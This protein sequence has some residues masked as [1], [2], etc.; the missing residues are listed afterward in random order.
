M[1]EKER[2]NKIASVSKYAFGV[3]AKTI[4]YSAKLFLGFMVKEGRVLELGPAE[5]V[6]TELLY[7]YFEDYTVV[8]GADMFVEQITK[9]YPK[10][11]GVVSLFEDYKPDRKFDNII[12]GHVLEH[13]ENP[14]EILRRCKSWLRDGGVVLAAVP[15]CDSIHRQAAVKMGLLDSV[16]Q[17]NAAD[18]YHGH[19]RVYNRKEFIDDFESADFKIIKEGGYWLKPLSNA[20]VEENWTDEMVTAFMELGEKYPEIAA[21]IYVVAGK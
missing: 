13:V 6:M 2:I 1:D 20:Q 12:L 16:K 10:I 17:L 15:N 4:I 9:K 3:N 18:I 14:R 7:P 21:E 19:R 5:G 11:Q 8:D